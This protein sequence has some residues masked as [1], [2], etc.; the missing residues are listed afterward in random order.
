MLKILFRGRVSPSADVLAELMGIAELMKDAKVAK[1]M[2]HYKISAEGSER[3]IT[4]SGAMSKRGGSPGNAALDL[5]WTSEPVKHTWESLQAEWGQLL[6]SVAT[7]C[8]SEAVIDG[9]E[10]YYMNALIQEADKKGL[11][12]LDQIGATK[13]DLDRGIAVEKANRYEKTAMALSLEDG[14][15]LEEKFFGGI[16]N[17]RDREAFEY[18]R[19]LLVHQ[20]VIILIG[21]IERAD[22]AQYDPYY[23]RILAN[24]FL[25]GDQKVRN[26]L[27]QAQLD[28]LK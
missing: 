21:K 14:S 1:A 26:Q 3:Q 10:A 18:R 8:T 12:T 15:F 17:D 27:S 20:K 9:V 5:K 28:L 11:F 22:D 24:N 4:A 6:L 23:S 2:G 25:A 16:G 13:D 7:Q 19:G